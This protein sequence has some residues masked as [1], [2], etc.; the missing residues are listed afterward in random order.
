MLDEAAAAA[1]AA[2]ASA[3]VS[4]FPFFFV[5]GHQVRIDDGRLAAVT[6]GIL[7]EGREEERER[8]SEWNA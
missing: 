3:E 8:K 4:I 6:S 1:A 7:L 5:C 2:E